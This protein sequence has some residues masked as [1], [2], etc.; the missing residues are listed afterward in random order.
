MAAVAPSPASTAA[1]RTTSR[2]KA[3]T[4]PVVVVSARA[5][6]LTRSTTL[7][8]RDT[9]G[10]TSVTRRSGASEETAR[11]LWLLA[12]GEA[13]DVREMA[14]NDQRGRQRREHD[15][16]GVVRA[17]RRQRAADGPDPCRG[18]RSD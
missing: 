8:P 13:A 18:Q 14:H 15:G 16:D 3:T 12:A 10:L 5:T 17:Q 11:Q 1:M 4:P 6:A 2:C 7:R 9:A